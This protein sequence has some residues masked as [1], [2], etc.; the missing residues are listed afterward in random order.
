MNWCIPTPNPNLTIITEKKYNFPLSLSTQNAVFLYRLFWGLLFVTPLLILS[1]TQNTRDI[2][3]NLLP[4][5]A[6]AQPESSPQ[7]TRGRRQCWWHSSGP[8]RPNLWP[9]PAQYLWQNRTFQIWLFHQLPKYLGKGVEELQTTEKSMDSV[10]VVR[11]AAAS[12]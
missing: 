12:A 7:W 10:L 6:S 2:S 1:K 8:R 3:A 5:L 9:P 4:T 11:V